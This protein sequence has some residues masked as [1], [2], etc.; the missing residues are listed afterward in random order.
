MP[1]PNKNRFRHPS[2]HLKSFRQKSEVV[3][4]PLYCK[5]FCVIIGLDYTFTY[6]QPILLFE[7]F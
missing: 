1:K 4:Q 3:K 5:F 2:Y 6:G 7:I